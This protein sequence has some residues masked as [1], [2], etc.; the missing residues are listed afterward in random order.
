MA[1]MDEKINVSVELTPSE[2]HLRAAKAFYDRLL[3]DSKQLD[4]MRLYCREMS[5]QLP[6]DVDPYMH[7]Q[8]VSKE[9]RIRYGLNPSDNNIVWAILEDWFKIKQNSPKPIVTRGE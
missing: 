1:N 2:A 9:L 5:R 6:C 7:N 8:N 4:N 3:F